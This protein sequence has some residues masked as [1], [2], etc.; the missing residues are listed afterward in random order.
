MFGIDFVRFVQAFFVIFPLVTFIHLLGHYTYIRFYGG[1]KAKI[2]LGCGKPILTIGPIE[3]RLFYFW[4]GGCEYSELAN[5]T[6]KSKVWIYTGGFLFNLMSI[7]V[8]YVFIY[9]SI[10]PANGFLYQFVYF[11]F[12]VLFFAVLPMDFPDGSPSDGKAIIQLLRKK[13]IESSADCMVCR[14]SALYVKDSPQ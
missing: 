7:S 13:N 4:F 11:S 12:Y 3:V 14:R 5:E 1:K 10:I 2:V 9:S 8:I 6:V